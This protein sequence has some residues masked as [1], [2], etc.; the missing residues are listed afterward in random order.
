MTNDIR[1][2]ATRVSA[3]TL[4]AALALVGGITACG[5]VDLKQQV[6]AAQTNL[7]HAKAASFTVRIA[8]PDNE[9]ASTAKTADDMNAARIF[10]A[11]SLTFTVDPAGDRTLGDAGKAKPK[12]DDPVSA[13]KASGA[14]EISY[15]NAGKTVL[16]LRSVGG[17]LY[18][19]LDPTQWKTV[20]GKPLPLDDMNG[21]DAPPGTGPAVSGIRAGKW[22]SLDLAGLY[23][24]AEELG[25]TK[26]NGANPA[27]L[28]PTRVQALAKK[29]VEAVQRNYTST[30]TNKGDITTVQ[31]KVKA[32]EALTAVLDTLG[33]PQFKDVL[34]A[35]GATGDAWL[36]QA[37]AAVARIPAGAVTG[38][39]TIRKDHFT[40]VAVDLGSI[41]ALA[42]DPEAK[43]VRTARLLVDVDDS[44]AAVT[45]PAADQV[46]QVDALADA[47]VGMAG[48][49]AGAGAPRTAG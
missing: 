39:V 44:A 45:A 5:K 3:A 34:S 33:D 30:S 35:F 25:L 49:F 2:R 23:T 20:A 8:D 28:D 14:F 42:T 21:P 36:G 10:K 9:L 24:R 6:D 4:V 11:A 32:K 1:R 7:S 43:K 22:L 18:A 38:S 46:V 16:A 47:V 48:A 37:K 31:V 40:Q 15:A 17:V 26:A 27:K 13:L 41:T 19:R 12:S 29:I